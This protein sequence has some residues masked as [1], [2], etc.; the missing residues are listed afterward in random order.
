[1]RIYVTETYIGER[2]NG[3]VIK[4]G[5]YDLDAPELFH[6]G[7]YLIEHGVAVVID[8][9]AEDETFNFEA[10]PEPEAVE[11]EAGDESVESEA[12]ENPTE[13]AGSEEVELASLTNAELRS[14]LDANGVDHSKAKTKA[15][16]LALFEAE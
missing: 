14:L 16:L 6:A 13:T 3:Q 11:E 12:Q 4:P 10:A 2:S 15:D 7:G 9:H 8:E 1:M 5:E